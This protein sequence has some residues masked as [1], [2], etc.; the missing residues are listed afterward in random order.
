MGIRAEAKKLVG[1]LC[2][3]PSKD[4]TVSSQSRGADSRDSEEMK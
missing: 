3:D 1:E 2:S 4:Q